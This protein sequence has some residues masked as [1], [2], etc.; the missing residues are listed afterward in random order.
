M[1]NDR[2]S[3]KAATAY[4]AAHPDECPSRSRVG[5]RTVYN[6]IHD[7]VFFDFSE[8]DLI[9]YRRKRYCH[10]SVRTSSHNR[11]GRSIEE[12]P[13]SVLS[14]SEYGHWEM[15]TVYSGKGKGAACLL[16]LTERMTRRERIY[17]IK[18]RTQKEV[19]KAL[20]ALERSLGSSSFRSTFKTITVDNGV[21]FLDFEALEMSCLTK[22]KRTTLY[23]CHSYSSWERGSNEN[24]NKLIRRHIPK[25]AAIRD[26]TKK[27]IRDIEHWIN[28]YPRKMFGWRSAADME[29]L[30]LMG[31]QP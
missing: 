30:V 26:Y 14:R 8:K 16:V 23:Y 24:A 3:P 25:G 6:Y 19:K 7:S 29:R 27:Q 17:K 11:R 15:D 9:S 12:R 1:R 22:I 28:H 20:D 10:K 21:E 5:W 31:G 18:S 4:L 13:E 2:Y